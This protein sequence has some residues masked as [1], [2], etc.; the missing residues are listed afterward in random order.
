MRRRLVDRAYDYFCAALAL[1]RSSWNSILFVP[2]VMID[3]TNVDTSTT[4]AGHPSS[5]PIVIAPT[6]MSKLSHPRGEMCFAEAAGLER[7]PFTVC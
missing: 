5:L 3:V 6:G 7:I 1:N 2:R 4:L